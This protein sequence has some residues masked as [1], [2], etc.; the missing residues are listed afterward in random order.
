M[1]KFSF[2]NKFPD[3]PAHFKLS[4]N[5]N[6]ENLISLGQ[7]VIGCQSRLFH[8]LGLMFPMLRKF[9][10]RSHIFF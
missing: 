8:L 5:F 10:K 7:Y 6:K 2:G 3:D 4:I 1:I 9:V